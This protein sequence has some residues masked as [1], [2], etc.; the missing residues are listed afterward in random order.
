M[1]GEPAESIL[2][3]CSVILKILR[4]PEA[5][6]F[7]FTSAPDGL[8]LIEA[9]ATIGEGEYIGGAGESI[10]DASRLLLRALQEYARVRY[11][12]LAVLFG[13]GPT[14]ATEAPPAPRILR[15]L[16]KKGLD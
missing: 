10:E 15:L 7:Q 6:Q 4:L 16:P 9:L 1:S 11:I 5:I 14:A 8:L 13:E 12:E 2:R 3:S